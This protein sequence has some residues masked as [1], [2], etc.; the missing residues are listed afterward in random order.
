MKYNILVTASTFG[1]ADD[2]PV[3][4]LEENS[5]KI[6]RCSRGRPLGE[7]E[8]IS[9]LPNVDGVIAGVDNFSSRVLEAASGR[10][11]VISRYGVGVDNIDLVAASRFGVVVTNIPGGNTEAVADMTWGL[12]LA[13][14]RRIPQFDRSTKAGLW[15]RKIVGDVYGKTLGI[16]GL[17]R[18]GKAVARR[19]T[20]FS[21]NLLAF[22]VLRD[23]GWAQRFGVK[24][25]DLDSLLRESDFVSLHCPLTESTRG[26][27]GMRELGIMKPSAYLINTARGALVDE[28]ALYEALRE[29]RIAGAAL[30]AFAE[31]PPVGSPLLSLDN[32]IATPHTASHTYSAMEKMG[33]QAAR[34][35]LAVLRGE[36]CDNIVRPG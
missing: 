28:G 7:S 23:D 5:C 20:G 26:I 27:I 29:G 11:K 12:I 4:F 33:W 30:D 8:L 35:L 32:V 9:I 15:E 19:A 17:G 16:I 34:N 31:E 22:D 2:G 3:R 14:S 25:V 21:M 1:E 6:M 10:L 36:A 24:Y 18:I 13:I